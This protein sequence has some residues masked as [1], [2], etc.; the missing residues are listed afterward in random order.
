ML[1]PGASFRPVITNRACTPPSLVPSGFGLK[2]ASRIGPVCVMN[3]G[4]VFLAPLIVATA[5]RGF[6]NG[7]EPPPLGWEWQERHWF[8]LKRGPRPLFE[9]KPMSDRKSTR[10]N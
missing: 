3:H 10:L 9:L 5:M 1:Q 6:R 8:E 4:M 2:R 7:L